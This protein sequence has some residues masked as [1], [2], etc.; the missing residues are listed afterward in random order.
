MPAGKKKNEKRIKKEAYW[1]KLWSALETYSKGVIVDCDNVSSK[2]ISFIRR[3]L[4]EKKAIMIMG[5]NTLIKAA[6]AYRN[7]KPEETD[8]DYEE[9]K[10]SWAPLP[11]IE[12]LSKL[13]KSNVGIIMTNGDLGDIKDVIENHKREAPAKVGSIA[14]DDVWI[15]AGSTGLDPKQTGF[16]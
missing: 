2:Q 14:Q 8:E 16:F 13:F 15:R 12:V 11:K 1:K 4:R 10:G 7:K 3:D 6:L 9:R 5:K